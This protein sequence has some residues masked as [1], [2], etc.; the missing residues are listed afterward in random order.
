VEAT[1]PCAVKQDRSTLDQRVLIVCRVGLAEYGDVFGSA[2][3]QREVVQVGH[4]PL[5]R[6]HQHRQSGP[7]RLERPAACWP[8]RCSPERRAKR[9]GQQSLPRILMSNLLGRQFAQFVVDER[10]QLLSDLRVA[11]LDVRR[12]L[13]SSRPEW[14]GAVNASHGREFQARRGETRTSP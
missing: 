6:T 5:E 4:R 2:I 12:D 13:R 11:L 10:Q 8:D 9:R 3:D 1:D 14:R 7:P